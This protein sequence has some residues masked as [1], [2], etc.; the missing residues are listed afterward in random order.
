MPD[1]FATG[2][3]D[4]EISAPVTFSGAEFPPLNVQASNDLDASSG[5]FAT[6]SPTLDSS[7]GFEAQTADG[8]KISIMSSASASAPF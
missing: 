5:F 3:T 8:I 4:P 1:I 2:T 7:G 6:S